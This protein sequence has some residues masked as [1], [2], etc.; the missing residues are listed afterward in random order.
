MEML[1]IK[2]LLLLL[3]FV[4]VVIIIISIIIIIINMTRGD[5]DIEG[6]TPPLVI[7][8]EFSLKKEY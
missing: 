4:V 8:N 3:F 2:S 7:L 5:E 1:L 6:G